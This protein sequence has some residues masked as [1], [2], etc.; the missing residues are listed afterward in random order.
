MIQTFVNHTDLNEA[1]TKHVNP[2]ASIDLKKAGV[3]Q[4]FYNQ[5]EVKSFKNTFSLA[6]EIVVYVPSESNGQLVNQETR[7]ALINQA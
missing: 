6:H 5:P 2:I 1:Y 7:Q 3:G 4:A